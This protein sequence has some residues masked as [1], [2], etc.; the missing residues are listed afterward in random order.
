M[1]ERNNALLQEISELR[2][3]LKE[4]KQDVKD[5]KEA[6]DKTMRDKVKVT[7][8]EGYT[9]RVKTKTLE[10]K[11]VELIKKNQKKKSA[12]LEKKKVLYVG[13]SV[14]HNVNFPQIENKTSTRIR[15]R[16]AYSACFDTVAKYP[17]KRRCYQS[18][19]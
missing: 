1:S 18:C 11:Q 10:N 14:A 19:S 16:K 15:T 12:F 2:K 7:E 9:Q 4:V 3:T 17:Q 6:V 5:T 8:S 13:D